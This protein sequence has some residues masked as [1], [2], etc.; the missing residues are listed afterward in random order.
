[1]NTKPRGAGPNRHQHDWQR[2]H[3][4]GPAPPAKKRRW[5]E[6]PN[7]QLAATG[8]T[9]APPRSATGYVSTV[10]VD[11]VS[12]TYLLIRHDEKTVPSKAAQDRAAA[13]P[14]RRLHGEP[15]PLARAGRRLR[16]VHV[17]PT[18][19]VSRETHTGV[20]LSAIQPRCRHRYGGGHWGRA[21]GYMRPPA[22]CTRRTVPDAIYVPV[23]WRGPSSEPPTSPPIVSALTVY[24]HGLVAGCQTDRPNPE[25]SANV[26]LGDYGELS[27]PAWCAPAEVAVFVHGTQRSHKSPPLVDERRVPLR[28]LSIQLENRTSE[29]I[30]PGRWR[31]APHSFRG[32]TPQFTELTA[33][34][35]LEHVHRLSSYERVAVAESGVLFLRSSL[36]SLAP[37]KDA[38]RNPSARSPDA[39][40]SG[41]TMPE[42]HS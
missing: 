12:G 9:A 5:E 34:N 20:R 40:R 39:P 27:G 16:N 13:T 36:C 26:G 35:P 17:K 21:D 23:A 1:M 30:H 25:T 31:K 4:L 32:A 28:K 41:R 24:H 3:R 19:R 29:R 2:S 42:S 33:W 14:A 37:G 6:L 7:Q 15:A 22:N 10:I 8:Q 38:W 18:R 11:K